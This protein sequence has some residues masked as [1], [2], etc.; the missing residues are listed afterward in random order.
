MAFTL[1]DLPY[2]HDALAGLGMSK[3][4]LEY[5]HDLH[6]K[7]YVDNGNKLIAGT[8]WEGKPVEQI[9]KG[10]YQKGADERH[11]V[12]PV[13]ADV[14]YGAELATFPGQQAP[15]VIGRHLQPVLKKMSLNVH[16]PA[17]VAA[18][19]HRAHLE[20]GGEEPAHVIDGEHRP[21]T[22]ALAHGLDHPRRF[23]RRHAERL[24]ADDMFAGGQRG[25]RLFDVDLVRRRDVDDIDVRRSIHR[26]VIVV[27][28]NLG[29][30]PFRGRGLRVLR[31]TA[32]PQECEIAMRRGARLDESTPGSGLGLSIARDIASE[33]GGT[34]ELGRSQLG[35]LVATVRLPGR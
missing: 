10:T 16:Y 9:V 31:R 30:A 3:E 22:P 32:N 15:V 11:R 17:E 24:F 6:H 35:G 2:A 4:T 21:A 12:D 5:H 34:L 20:D 14:A 1:P 29:D 19:D 33:Y 26:L 7:A 8:E 23:L 28:V 25:E 27:A 13:R 18:L